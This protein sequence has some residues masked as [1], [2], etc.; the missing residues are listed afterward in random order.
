MSATDSRFDLSD[1]EV[2]SP[3]LEKNADDIG[4]LYLD[5]AEAYMAAGEY[6]SARPLLYRLVRSTN[7]NL[8]S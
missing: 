7:Y 6:A 8:V 5:I 3:L 1:Q 2:M 4:D